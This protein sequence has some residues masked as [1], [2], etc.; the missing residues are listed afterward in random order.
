MPVSFILQ[1]HDEAADAEELGELSSD[2]HQT[3]IYAEIDGCSTGTAPTAGGGI[4]VMERA[5]DPAML[6]ALLVILASTNALK[7]A[8]K[9][10][11]TWAS[12]NN[13]SVKVDSGSDRTTIEFTGRADDL[14]KAAELLAAASAPPADPSS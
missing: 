7:A 13:C 2:L 10:I 6:D 8:C 4:N 5:A 11:S 14:Q 1:V 9:V 3:L 12:L